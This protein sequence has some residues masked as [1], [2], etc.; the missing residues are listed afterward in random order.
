MQ[1]LGLRVARTWAFNEG[2][3]ASAGVYDETQFQGLDYVV[4]TAGSK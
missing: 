4:A 3:P 1:R 2:M